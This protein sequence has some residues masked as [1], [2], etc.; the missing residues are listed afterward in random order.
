MSAVLLHHLLA[1]PKPDPDRPALIDGHRQLSFREFAE[2]VEQ[3][4]ARLIAAGIRRGD[5]VAILLPKSL[6][7][8]EA[9]FAASRADAVFVRSTGAQGAADPP[10]PGGLRGPCRGCRRR[11]AHPSGRGLR[12]PDR[13]GHPRS[14]GRRAGAARTASSQYRAGPGRHPL[15]IRFDRRPEG[16]DAEPCQPDRGDADRPHLSL[17][18]GGGP[19]PL[20]VAVQL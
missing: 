16:R 3:L 8:C 17:D 10:Y 7:E 20:P 19:H 9:I 2:R 5:R 12:G 15:H 1:L 14:D 13:S 6:E 11:T 4:A 18:H